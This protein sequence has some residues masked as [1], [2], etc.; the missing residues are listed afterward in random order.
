MASIP[1]EEL[2][3]ISFIIGSH[4]WKSDRLPNSLAR[5]A[6][7]SSLSKL[8]LVLALLRGHL[9]DS[10]QTDFTQKLSNDSF[11]CHV[12]CAKQ[13][14]MP[15]F[16]LFYLLS[17]FIYFKFMSG[18]IRAI[19]CPRH[20]AHMHK[21]LCLLLFKHC[22]LLAGQEIKTPAFTESQVVLIKRSAPSLL[23]P[24]SDIES[25]KGK[26]LSLILLK[27]KRRIEN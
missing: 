23:T 22:L 19:T 20:A 1:R 7:N 17:L 6:F 26:A 16:L 21:P 14:V 25:R 4:L 8:F 2:L 12:S 11:H 13:T 24:C 27:L 18:Q 10:P 15:R 9:P 5:C 3:P